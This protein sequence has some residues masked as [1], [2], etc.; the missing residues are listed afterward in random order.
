MRVILFLFTTFFSL[1]CTAQ[2]T[3]MN[4]ST[5]AD[6][7]LS[8]D[9]K[10]LVV[11]VNVIVLEKDDGTGNF[12]LNDPEEKQLLIDYF[13]IINKT[14]SHF[15]QPENLEGC[16]TGTDF[17][18][19]SKI[20]FIFNFIPYR[21]SYAWNFK[22]A[23]TNLENKNY[24]GFIPDDGWYLK[25]VDQKISNDKKI[26]KGIL[27]YLTIDG[28]HYDRLVASQG[29]GYDL[30]GV[31]ASEF[32]TKNNLNRPSR[33]HAPNRYLKYLAHRYANPIEYKTTWKDTRQW[34]LNDAV[35][36]A[37]E[38]GH[39]F[40]LGH[41]NSYHRENECGYS[42][43]TQVWTAPR[44]YLQPTE[45]LKA[46]E[47]LRTTN[48][49]QFVT[50]DSFLGNTFLIEEST[51]WDQ[52]QRL[53]SNL[54]LSKNVILT[55]TQPIIISPQAKI[56]FGKNSKIVFAGH[57]SLKDPYGRVSKLP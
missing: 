12:N 7:K 22:N 41:S 31:E 49:I 11:R 36:T 44:N 16:Y 23:G 6:F 20:R 1:V 21:D 2:V 8:S 53:Y 45:L 15:T 42:F 5:I 33:I 56:I 48:L 32:P 4:Q 3:T 46:H 34:H 55:I 57:G 26:P 39:S 43:M 9:L 30:R 25:E 29:K 52:P 35:G 28:D 18:E 10:P 13:E 27:I 47:R 38:L 51:T 50:E 37:H 17:Y 24:S 14:W 54:K 40:D 19:D